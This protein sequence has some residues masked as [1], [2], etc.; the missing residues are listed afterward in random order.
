MDLN[1]KSTEEI[2]NGKHQ[3]AKRPN[4]KERKN[5]PKYNKMCLLHCKRGSQTKNIKY[6]KTQK[7]KQIKKRTHWSAERWRSLLSAFILIIVL[8][9]KYCNTAPHNHHDIKEWWNFMIKVWWH[10]PYDYHVLQKCKTYTC[11]NIL[12]MIWKHKIPGWLEGTW[13]IIFVRCKAHSPNI[14][15]KHSHVRS[16]VTGSFL[17]S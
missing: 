13:P 14:V 1:K 8:V 2:S 17:I 3:N 11:N 12:Y 9:W 10:P 7:K 15:G 6:D 16:H 5:R 4:E